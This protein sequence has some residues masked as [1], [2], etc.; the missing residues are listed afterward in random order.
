MI[1]PNEKKYIDVT[2]LINKIY[3]KSNCHRLDI[4]MYS[5][6]GIITI[7]DNAPAADVAEVKRGH[8]IEDGSVQICSECGEEHEWGEYRATYCEDCGARMDGADSG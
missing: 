7:L 2:E 6:R 5:M 8:W 4:E 1:M 3:N